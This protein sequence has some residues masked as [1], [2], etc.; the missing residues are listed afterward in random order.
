MGHHALCASGLP[1]SIHYQLHAEVVEIIT[2]HH[3]RQ[4]PPRFG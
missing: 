4:T 2:I 3:H 1:G